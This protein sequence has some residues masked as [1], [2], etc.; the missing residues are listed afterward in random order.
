MRTKLGTT[1]LVA[2]FAL[3]GIGISYAGFTDEIYIYG[4]AETATVEL[5]IIDFS[6]TE[7]YKVW[8]TGQPTNEI[9]RVHE[10]FFPGPNDNVWLDD[11]TG[12]KLG[13]VQTAYK[14]C[15]VEFVAGAYAHPCYLQPVNGEVREVGQ[16]VCYEKVCMDFVNMFPCQDFT[17]DFTIEYKGTIPAKL[18]DFVVDTYAIGGGVLPEFKDGMNWLE[19]LWDMGMEDPIDPDFGIHVYGHPVDDDGEN[20]Q[21]LVTPGYQLHPGDIIH[22]YVEIHLPQDN[23]FQGLSG[24]FDTT[25]VVKQ[26]N[27]VDD[28]GNDLMPNGS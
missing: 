15:Q 10:W 13:D 6:S 11:W 16:E 21:I 24:A 12:I 2:M 5:C 18:L 20:D 19:Y 9:H 3:A 4:E 28:Q 1:F 27:E 22:V 25:L 8:G 7:V 14:D 26:W 23:D 17:A